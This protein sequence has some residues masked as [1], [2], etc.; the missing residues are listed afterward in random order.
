MSVGIVVA[1]PLSSCMITFSKNVVYYVQV[2][3]VHVSCWSSPVGSGYL[4][5][6]AYKA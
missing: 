1:I 6:R 3:D 5:S 4:S 2:N